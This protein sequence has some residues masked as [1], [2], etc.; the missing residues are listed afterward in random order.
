MVDLFFKVFLLIILSSCFSLSQ[1][2]TNFEIIDSL[3]ISIVNEISEKMDVESIGVQ[4]N[5]ADKL[6]ENRI[7]NAFSKKFKI[8]LNDTNKANI[9]RI[10]GFKNR[11]SYKRESG[12]FLKSAKLRR[13][14]E[15][16]LFCTLISNN[17][18]LTSDVFKRTFSDYIT[19]NEI[20]K[21]EDEYKFTQGEV[22]ESKSNFKGLIEGLLIVSSIGIAVYLL[23]VIRK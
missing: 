12:G 23:F 15:I 7:L 2:L 14:I 8:F 3:L 18:L 13:D 4:S 19:Y 22:V 10:D 11:I 16:N 1:K 20:G 6:L 17:S 5:L 21:V 9:V